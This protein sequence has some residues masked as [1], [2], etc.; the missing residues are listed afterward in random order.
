MSFFHKRHRFHHKL[1]GLHRSHRLH[2]SKPLIKSLTDCELGSELSVIGVHAGHRAKQRLAHLGIVPG[3]KISMKKSAP[4]KG[5]I[6]IV[7]KGSSLVIGR[8][9]ASK[10]LV[11]C[12]NIEED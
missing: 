1:H 10:I 12:N 2:H 4:F 6:N 11:D 5:P 9:L 7:V 8:G 3:V